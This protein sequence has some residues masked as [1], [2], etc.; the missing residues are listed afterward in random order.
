MPV[1]FSIATRPDRKSTSSSVITHLLHPV[2]QV[3]DEPIQTGEID[4]FPTR[5]TD[6]E[7]E[8]AVRIYE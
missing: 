6:G 7:S 3:R 8:S 5:L 4:L 2:P 1:Q